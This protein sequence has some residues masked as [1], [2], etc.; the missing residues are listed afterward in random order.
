[1]FEEVKQSGE[2]IVL[3]LK[4]HFFRLESKYTLKDIIAQ[5]RVDESIENQL[6]ELKANP[7]N[8]SASENLSVEVNQVGRQVHFKGS[9]GAERST[10]QENKSQHECCCVKYGREHPQQ[11]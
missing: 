7:S 2:N 9:R 10:K 8:I 5:G 3:K 4:S 6:K 11:I 1:M